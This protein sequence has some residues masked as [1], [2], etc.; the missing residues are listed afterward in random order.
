MTQNNAL[1]RRRRR[2][3]VGADTDADA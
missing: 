2:R 3:R 1:M